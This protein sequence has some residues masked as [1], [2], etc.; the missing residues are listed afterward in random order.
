MPTVAILVSRHAQRHLVLDE[1]DDEQL[2]LVAGDFLLLDGQD[3]ADAVSRVDDVFVGLEP[4]TLRGFLRPD[5]APPPRS[6]GR[7][8][9]GRVQSSWRSC[10]GMLLVG[11]LRTG[12]CLAPRAA[13]RDGDPPARAGG[14]LADALFQALTRFS[15]HC[16]RVELTLPDPV[17]R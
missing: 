7:W 14:S 16:F 9:A 12:F 6:A 13:L 15:S 11:R 5:A 2:E 3:L 4:V 8:A 10:R 1:V 17:P